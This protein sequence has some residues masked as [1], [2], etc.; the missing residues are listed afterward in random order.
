ML[1]LIELVESSVALLTL[2]A[3]VADGERTPTPT[4]ARLEVLSAPSVTVAPLKLP[5]DSAAPLT[6]TAWPLLPFRSE[7]TNS[8]PQQAPPLLIVTAPTSLVPEK[9]RLFC[10]LLDMLIVS[11]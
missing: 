1:K 10:V 7:P 8:E 4:E 11:G 6:V 5:P 9:L 3:P 2:I